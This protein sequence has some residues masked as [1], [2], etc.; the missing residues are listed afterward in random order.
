M[1]KPEGPLPIAVR[2]GRLLLRVS[3]YVGAYLAGIVTCIVLTPVEIVLASRPLVDVYPW[4]SLLGFALFFFSPDTADLWHVGLAGLGIMTL[5]VA[6]FFLKWPRLLALRPWLLAFPVG[7]V[8]ATGAY[9]IL[10]GSI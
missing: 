4:F 9:Y 2:L 5:G 10:A 7:F 3:I 6:A 1:V 8:G